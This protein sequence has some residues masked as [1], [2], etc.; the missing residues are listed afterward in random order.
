MRI[1]IDKKAGFCP[2]VRNAIRKADQH[3]E[4]EG[5]FSCLG[6]LLH[7]D[8]EME[9]LKDSGL[10]IARH[11]DLQ[12]LSGEKILF[13]AHGEPPETFKLAEEHHLEVIDA[14]CAVVRKL[15][16]QVANAAAVMQE[17]NGQVVIFG[18]KDHAEVIGLLGNAKGIG[19]VVS[20]M[21]DLGKLDMERPIRLF[22]QTTMDDAVF[23]MIAKSIKEQHYN[24][25]KEPD[26]EAFN[27]ICKYVLNRVPSLK[28]FAGKHEV[29]IFVS[30]R[31]SSNGKKL[32]KESKAINAETYFISVPEELNREWFVNKDKIGI[33]GSASTPEWLMEE[34]AN[35]IKELM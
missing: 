3:L 15:Q 9:R 8:K 12:D 19:I 22:S 29:I 28:E 17:K 20:S 5:S 21:Q 35:R 27:T 25:A 10:Q 18:K 11:R 30:G 33:S 16:I 7:N 23:N 4:K 26:F 1:T 2:G 24:R 14:T 13:R 32:F 6:S 34:V 31:E